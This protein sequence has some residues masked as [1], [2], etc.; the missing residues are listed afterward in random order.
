MKLHIVFEL[1][2]LPDV[3]LSDVATMTQVAARAFRTAVSPLGKCRLLRLK[4]APEKAPVATQ[5]PPIATP[6]PSADREVAP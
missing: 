4:Q 1:D 3:G 5:E 6:E 2:T